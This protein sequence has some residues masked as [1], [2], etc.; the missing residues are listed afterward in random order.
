MP[1]VSTLTHQSRNPADGHGKICCSHS[2]IGPAVTSSPDTRAGSLG[3]LR[4]GDAGVH[5][6]C[7]GPNTWACMAGSASV[8]CNGRPVVRLGDATAHCGGMGT[9]VE[10][11]ATVLVGDGGGADGGSGGFDGSGGGGHDTPKNDLAKLEDRFN[12]VY[13]TLHPQAPDTRNQMA[14]APTPLP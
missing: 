7:C 6:S 14:T 5:S 1:P 9:M 3:V 13:D 11:Y 2:V 10:G 12:G 4:V 8:F